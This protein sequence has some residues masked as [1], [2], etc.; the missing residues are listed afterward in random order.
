MLVKGYKLSVVRSNGDDT[1]IMYCTLEISSEGRSEVF[2]PHIH[3]HT[4]TYNKRVT[5]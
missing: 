5:T 2:S 3:T 1:I 4:H